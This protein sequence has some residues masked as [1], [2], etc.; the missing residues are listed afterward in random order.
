MNQLHPPTSAVPGSP[1]LQVSAGAEA[2]LEQQCQFQ[3]HGRTLL[4]KEVKLQKAVTNSE[5][6]VSLFSQLASD[7]TRG[8][9]FKLH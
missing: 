8:N 5:V 9:G 7:R 3:L 6:G 1:G 4:A 2:A